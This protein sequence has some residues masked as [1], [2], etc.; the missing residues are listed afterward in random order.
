MGL[1]QFEQR[2]ARQPDD[3]TALNWE[4]PQA[5]G[6]V[7]YW[8]FNSRALTELVLGGINGVGDAVSV[9]TP[10]G[11]AREFNGS[12]QVQTT[13]SDRVINAI[14]WSCCAF[15]KFSSF[16]NA[17]NT[18]I[19][20]NGSSAGFRDFHVKSDGKLAPYIKT[21]GG[22]GSSAYDGTGA[23]TLSTGVWYHL[24]FTYSINGGLV[25]YVN[26]NVDG[27]GVI[28]GN[29]DALTG[30]PYITVGS[31]QPA[32]ADRYINGTVFDA[33]FYDR[34]LSALEIRQI[35]REPWQ[36]F[37]PRRI[38]VPVSAASGAP[39]LAAIAAS[40]LTASG[41]RLTVT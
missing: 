8:P 16:T 15:V 26:A 14:A 9:A 37:A 6:L 21:T 18:L 33:R 28:D 23:N 10:Y 35:Y 38:W 25:G 17:Y 11:L 24:A 22:I 3:T 40:N 34:A 29:A 31:N 20:A 12:V 7:H 19:C 36:L 1:I 32:F 5:N 39:T 4:S 2:R 27:T 13:P 30:T 41:A